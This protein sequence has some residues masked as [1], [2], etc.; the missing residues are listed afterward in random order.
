MAVPGIIRYYNLSY[1]LSNISDSDIISLTLNQDEKPYTISGL[2]P[3]SLYEVNIS[4]FTVSTGPAYTIF[5]MTDEAGLCQF[6]VPLDVD[7]GS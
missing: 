7:Y 2:N 5:V 6:V 3:Y 1:R 4:A